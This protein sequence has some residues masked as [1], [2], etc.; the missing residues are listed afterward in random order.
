MAEALTQQL[1]QIAAMYRK[2][3]RSELA[4]AVYRQVLELQSSTERFDSSETAVALYSLG[5]VYASTDREMQAL[6]YFKMALRIWEKI[7]ARDTESK[8]QL[9]AKDFLRERAREIV[10][11]TLQGLE[12][13]LHE[14]DAQAL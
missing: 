10:S 7:G 14:P 6:P 12:A 3:N 13:H 5:D 11:T 2:R 8:M 4:E 9:L 1:L